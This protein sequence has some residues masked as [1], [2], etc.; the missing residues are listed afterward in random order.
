MEK[1]KKIKNLNNFSLEDVL[2]ILSLRDR[3]YLYNDPT[4]P[5]C[6]CLWNTGKLVQLWQLN[7]PFSKQSQKCKNFIKDLIPKEI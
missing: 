7:K 4:R 1:E 5:A 2:S 6:W 3:C